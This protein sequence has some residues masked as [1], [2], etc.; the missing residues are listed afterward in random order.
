MRIA[1]TL[2]EFREAAI[3]KGAAA[4]PTA[5]DA[6][7]YERMRAAWLE[8]CRSGADGRAAFDSLL[9]D[10]SRYVRCW[11]ATQ[12][13][14]LGNRGALEVLEKDSVSGDLH[15][16]TCK[17]TIDEWRAGRLRPPFG[18]GDA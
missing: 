7:L 18:S 10:E 2:A 1:Q 8:L 5:E 17:V 6:E 12:L 14:A 3:R 11:A 9:L 4:G 13:L 16:F 15:G